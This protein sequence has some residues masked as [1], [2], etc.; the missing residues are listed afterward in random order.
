VRAAELY[1]AAFNLLYCTPSIGLDHLLCFARAFLQTHPRIS[2]RKRFFNLSVS[3][4]GETWHFVFWLFN[5]FSY[6]PD[7]QEG[8]IGGPRNISEVR[9]QRSLG[10]FLSLSLLFPL[11][12]SL[13]SLTF[14]VPS[15]SSLSVL[16]R[17][18]PSID[19]LHPQQCLPRSNLLQ[20]QPLKG[21][22]SYVGKKHFFDVESVQRQAQTTYTSAEQSIRRWQVWFSCL[23]A[24]DLES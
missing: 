7:L 6:I 4:A 10:S 15:A 12:L 8:K 13:R 16:P 23:G 2:S 22:A 11:H 1:L 5:L 17:T 9:K 20:T 19:S 24:R 14:S 21:I 3:F 18:A